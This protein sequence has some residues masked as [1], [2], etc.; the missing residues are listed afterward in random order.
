MQVFVTPRA[1]A[2]FDKIVTYLRKKWGE[3]TVSAF[4]NRT[5]N[6]LKILGRYPFLG[7]VEHE[8][9]RGYLLTSQIRLLYR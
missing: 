6:T 9:I 4:I 7:G 2:E 1:A 8:D 3:K 5:N